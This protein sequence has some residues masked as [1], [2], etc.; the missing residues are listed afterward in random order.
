[1]GRLRVLVAGALLMGAGALAVGDA[2]A[3][4]PREPPV[5]VPGRPPSPEEVARIARGFFVTPVPL[6][7]AGRNRALV[8]LGSYLVNAIGGCNDCHTVPPFAAGGNPYQGQP[9]IFNASRH[10]AG[11]KAFGAVVSTNLTPDARGRPGGL[12]LPDF[13][14][15]MRSGRASADQ[16]RI[17]QVMPWPSYAAMTDRDL[18]AIYEYLSAI[19]SL[20]TP[21]AQAPQIRGSVEPAAPRMLAGR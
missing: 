1:M 19:P 15:V 6:N 18:T 20:Q 21:P 5:D 3:Q 7:L 14:A 4:E 10:L 8:G 11:G 16:N 13:I 12:T 9:T 2:G 17:L